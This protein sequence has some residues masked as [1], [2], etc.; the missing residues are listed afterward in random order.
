[1]TAPGRHHGL[2]SS[3]EAAT[4]VPSPEPR[5]ARWEASADWPLSTAALLFLA[6]Y[7]WPVL[8]PGL[9]QRW[10][11]GCEVVAW[12]AWSMF[13]VD[14]LARVYLSR[15]RRRFVLT[16]LPDLAVIALPL[17][18]PLRLLRLVTLLNFVNRRAA[19]KVRGRLP[20]YVLIA[21]AL[22]LFVSSVAVLDAERGRPGANINGFGD[23]LWWSVTTITTVGYGDLYPTT[24]TGRFVAAGLMVSGIALLG[25]VTASFA[26]W[27]LAKIREGEQAVESAT[28][29]EVQELTRE[30]QELRSEI[31]EFRSV[32]RDRSLP[33]E[34]RGGS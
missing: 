2:V 20:L 18:R 4:L 19:D 26:S 3:P 33:E 12:L 29:Q 5:R 13:G 7:A 10:V 9:D 1:M 16:H 8:Q 25:V 23:A 15:R 6:A 31:A 34:P 30:V 11:R 21:G 17:L 27:L 28:Q 24:A 14:Y 32:Q 22:I